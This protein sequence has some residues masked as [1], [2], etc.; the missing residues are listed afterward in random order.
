LISTLPAPGCSGADTAPHGADL[1]LITFDTFRPDHLARFGYARATM[2]F[3][4]DWLA[5]ACSFDR[6]YSTSSWTAPAVASLFAGLY[7]KRHGVVEGLSVQRRQI[8]S[9][10][11][12]G[13]TTVELRGI[14]ASTP[15]LA[16]R[17]A[18]AG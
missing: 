6:A 10:R 7:P 8:E 18:A 4:D 2:P 13:H 12:A 9:A 16:Q 11:A 15:R 1:V 14:A 5:G 17:R 3:V